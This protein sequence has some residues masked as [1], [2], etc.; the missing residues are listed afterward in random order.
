LHTFFERAQTILHQKHEK[1]FFTSL[2][3]LCDEIRITFKNPR[4]KNKWFAF[5]AK[6][7][8]QA[9]QY[10]AETGSIKALE[11]LLD[12]VQDYILSE[13]VSLHPYRSIILVYIGVSFYNFARDV[14]HRYAAPEETQY[15]FYFEFDRYRALVN[16]YHRKE[17]HLLSKDFIMNLKYSVTIIDAAFVLNTHNLDNRDLSVTS[18]KIKEVMVQHSN[19]EHRVPNLLM[20]LHALHWSKLE[21][22][23]ANKMTSLE[24]ALMYLEKYR[25]GKSIFS[26]YFFDAWYGE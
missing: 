13:S 16:L 3:S 15:D 2:E 26:T 8:F 7:A 20:G 18:E 10:E 22:I 21:E 9:F 4:P 17:K 24:V 25:N 14:K 6:I 12:L 11:W 23:T 19:P 1:E 5:Y